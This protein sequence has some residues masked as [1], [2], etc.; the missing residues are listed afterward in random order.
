MPLPTNLCR[1]RTQ[2]RPVRAIRCMVFLPRGLTNEAQRVLP[3]KAYG[4]SS[5]CRFV[6]VPAHA[7]SCRFVSSPELISS[8]SSNYVIS[9]V[10]SGFGSCWFVPVLAHA[11]ACKV[12]HEP[13]LE[14]ASSC[15]RSIRSVATLANMLC[16]TQ[17]N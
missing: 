4:S 6:V 8:G 3:C 1:S 5:S 10:R 14:F 13:K 16:N 12:V 17:A 15:M 2:I 7:S 9:P 11:G